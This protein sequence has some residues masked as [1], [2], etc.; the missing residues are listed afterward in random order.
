MKFPPQVKRNPKLLTATRENQATPP[1]KGDE[2][3]FPCSTSSAIPSALSKLGRS[4]HSLY[5]TQEVP[6]DTRRSLRGSTSFRQLEKGL[7][8]LNSFRGDEGSLSFKFI[9]TPQEESSH[10]LNLERNP[11]VP[12]KFERTPSMHQLQIRPDCHAAYGVEP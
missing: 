7:V 4:L 8:F 9:L 11:T 5:A 10:L 1:S 2:A 12:G 3:H 6:I